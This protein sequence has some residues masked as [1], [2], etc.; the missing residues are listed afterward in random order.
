M[1]E[2]KYYRSGEIIKDHNGTDL[3][4]LREDAK[5]NNKFFIAKAFDMKNKRDCLLKFA[6]EEKGYKHANLLREG[7]FR[8][9]HPNIEH[10]YG[11]FRGEAPDG[12]MIEGVSV[13][14]IDGCDLG[15]YR[16]KLEEDYMCGEITEEQMEAIIFRQILQML[17]AIN[18][19]T[20]FADQ[21]YLHRDIKPG[22]IMIDANGEVKLV[23]FDYAH[24]SGSY[25]TVDVKEKYWNV[26]FSSGYTS[27]EIFDNDR[28][29]GSLTSEL[30]SVGRTMFFWLNNCHYYPYDQLTRSASAEWG[31]YVS[32]ESLRYGFEANK[33]R[34]KKKY[35]GK[36]Y[37]DLLQIMNKMCAAPGDER[38]DSVS[39]I[40]EDMERFL[41][42]HCGYS[43]KVYESLYGKQVLHLLHDSIAESDI[44]NHMMV[45]YRINGGAKRGKPL[46]EYTVRDIV[47]DNRKIL[48][49]YNI[50]NQL[51]CI[52][53]QGGYTTRNGNPLH[54]DFRIHNKDIIA[55]DKYRIEFT[56]GGEG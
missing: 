1:S 31:K 12:T 24:I 53:V 49:I 5:D 48:M 23:D 46:Y 15:E 27:P 37:S 52:P 22:N 51:Y 9:F 56:V 29:W 18:Y 45:G 54:G 13:E 7:N 6:E 2:K 34:F 4:I 50:S 33:S 40:I 21:M 20:T 28:T 32:D 17:H 11:C 25:K 16:K 41:F 19:Y 36:Q 55:F 44:R 39:S 30:Y 38:Y 3:Y 42:G 43:T 8:F 47:I 10:I 14:F 35:L 26:G